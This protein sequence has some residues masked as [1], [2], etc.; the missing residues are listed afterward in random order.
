MD[1]LRRIHRVLVPGGA[2]I[3]TQPVSPLPPVE[4][5][6]GRVGLLDMRGWMDL[7]AEVDG[8]VA[9]A[10]GHGLFAIEDE[11]RYRVVDEFASGAELVEEAREWAG[12]RVDDELVA[13]LTDLDGPVLLDQEIRLRVLRAR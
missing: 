8:R 5:H 13:R 3:D 2:V 11:R 12:T 7:I 9:E 4:T 10:V 6:S 1:A